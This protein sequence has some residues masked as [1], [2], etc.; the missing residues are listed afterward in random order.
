MTNLS[1]GKRLAWA[2]GLILL[3]VG[4]ITGIATLRLQSTSSA[5]REMMAEPIT[6][7]RL[8]EDWYRNLYA[9][10][11]RTTAVVKSTDDALAVFFAEE[12]AASSK[13]SG[14]YQKAVEALLRSE[15]EKALFQSI[16]ARRKVYLSSRDQVM[17]LKKEGNNAEAT[18][19]FDE[20]FLP[21]AKAYL[22]DMDLLMKYQR[23]AI[24]AAA[25]K[26]DGQNAASRL[27]LLA[28]GSLALLLGTLLAVLI[29]RGITRPISNAVS[30]AQRV[31]AGDLSG[32]IEV[33]AMG[34]MGALLRALQG[35]QAHLGGVLSGV[36]GSADSVATASSQIASGNADLSSRTEQQAGALQEMSATMGELDSTVRSNADNARQA[37]Q[38]A[39]QASQ[40]AA[41][42][43]Q[44]VEQVIGTMRGIND[45]ARRIADI[46]GVIDG[47]AFQTNILALNAAVE[48]ARA[49]EQG[50]GFA[51]VA[52]EVRSLASRSAAAAKEI[53]SLIGGSVQQVEQGTVLV[54]RAGAT[55]KEIVAAIERVSG[56]VSEISAASVEQSAG[57]TQMSE[58]VSRIDGTTQQNA[59]LVEEGAA[60]AESLKYQAQQL[61]QTVAV[62][63]LSPA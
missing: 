1:I 24:D 62:F 30:A 3:L 33:D 29:T 9:G 8:I 36:R 55:M 63:R 4:F 26:V 47:I 52:G 44:V 42:G 56:I 16:S 53:K 38:L 57:V 10:V 40:V 28:L 20:V 25:A 19:V 2:F 43:G 39:V 7:A 23:D 22:G 15:D 34:E 61:L 5:T 50:R 12:S 54:D 35:M 11:K 46:I 51:V 58:A 14:E 45:S 49:G 31:A 48:A 60:A 13:A 37:S 59:A 6:K 41:T 18:K 21:G 27:L 17:K 32:T